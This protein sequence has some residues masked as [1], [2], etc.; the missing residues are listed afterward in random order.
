MSDLDGTE[1]V[2]SLKLGF[3]HA[4]GNRILGPYARLDIVVVDIDGYSERM[5]RPSAVGSGTALRID[6]QSYACITTAF[7]ATAGYVSAQTWGIWYPQ[8]IAEYVHEFDND[9][10][11][12]TGRFVDAPTFSFS[13]PIDDP[14][15]DFAH[16]GVSSSFVLNSGVSTFLSY[17]ALVGYEDLTTHLVE[18]GLRIPFRILK[19]F[20]RF[21]SGEI[22]RRRPRNTSIGV[23]VAT[24]G[25]RGTRRG[26]SH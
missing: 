2:G 1:I 13:M 20:F 26:R 19:G 25:I 11:N 24:I 7:G 12:I 17:Q 6:D 16:V 10:E 4:I 9:A 3:D 18:I 8:V 22:S 14:D 5:S 23:S 21:V 15:H